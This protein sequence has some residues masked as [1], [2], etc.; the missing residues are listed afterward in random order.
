MNRGEATDTSAATSDTFIESLMDTDLYSM[1][2]YFSDRNPELI[3]ELI[4]RSVAIEEAGLRRFA[5]EE[6]VDIQEAFRTLLT[7]LAV[8]YYKSVTG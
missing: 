3:E 4:E 8:R 1:G 2:A 5:A 6:G 7:G